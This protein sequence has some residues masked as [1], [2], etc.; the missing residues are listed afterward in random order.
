MISDDWC[1]LQLQE[2][3]SS[4]LLPIY[5]KHRQEIEDEDQSKLNSRIEAISQLALA[6]TFLDC[7]VTPS[8]LVGEGRIG[9]LIAL[10]LTQG[11]DFLP[12]MWAVLDHDESIETLL[13]SF[14]K[15]SIPLF[16][17]LTLQSL[18]TFSPHAVEFGS[19]TCLSVGASRYDSCILSA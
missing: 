12:R 8:M 17:T 19:F 13:S 7:G 10:S 6:R 3:R 5:L 4:P 2:V 11:R 1:K 18:P 9:T 14:P 15:I 16:S